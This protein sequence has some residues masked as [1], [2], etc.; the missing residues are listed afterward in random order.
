MSYVTVVPPPRGRRHRRRSYDELARTV[1][2]GRNVRPV[3]TVAAQT[4][5]EFTSLRREMRKAAPNVPAAA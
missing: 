5:S 3:A 1:A 2:T 4:I